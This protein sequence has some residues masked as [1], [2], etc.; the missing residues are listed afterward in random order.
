L[1]L[2]NEKPK[3]FFIPFERA[4]Q[5]ILS[6]TSIGIT[7]RTSPAMI[8][9]LASQYISTDKAA[10]G[11]HAS[12]CRR[13]KCC[14][15]QENHPAAGPAV[16]LDYSQSLAVKVISM[17]E[18]FEDIVRLPP[19]AAEYLRKTKFFFHDITLPGVLQSVR[20]GLA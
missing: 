13:A 6:R 2:V 7:P 11:A 12:G 3:C 15:S 14:I 17:L 4:G 8:T 18:C 16:Q 9:Y 10:G 5:S 20:I 19:C 1:D